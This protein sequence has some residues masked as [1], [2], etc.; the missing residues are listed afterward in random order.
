MLNY[1]YAKMYGGKM[2]LRFDDTNP[3]TEKSKFAENI[4]RD[5]KTLQIYPDQTTYTSDYF[6]QL[7]EQMKK[8]ISLGLAYADDTDAAQMKVERDAG[9]ESKYREASIEDNLKRFDLMLRGLKEEPK[10]DAKVT[11]KGAKKD[12]NK[13]EEKKETTNNNN[14]NKKGQK[15]EKKVPAKVEAQANDE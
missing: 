9:I 2:I 12:T 13:K 14:N 8:L 10:E 6:E 7:Q 5:L 4:I 11:G 15:E 3:S 1:H